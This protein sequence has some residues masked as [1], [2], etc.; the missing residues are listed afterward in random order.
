MYILI[1]VYDLLVAAKTTEGLNKGTAEVL[2]AV[3]AH[4]LGEPSSWLGMH[5]GRQGES[6]PIRVGHRQYAA[7]ILK[8]FGFEATNPAR[9]AMSTGAKLTK[10]G[11]RCRGQ[12]SKSAK[13]S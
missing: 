8:R 6:G 9:L 10:A 5:T 4:D 7:S 12:W 2:G 11:M 3:K 1:Y 13:S